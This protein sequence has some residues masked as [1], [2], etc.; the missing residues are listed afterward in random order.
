VTSA[1]PQAAARRLVFGLALIGNVVANAPPPELD[2]CRLGDYRAPTRK[3]IA[4]GIVLDTEA[5]EAL[6]KS[7][8]AAWIDVL[9]APRRPAN[10]PAAALW[11]PLPHR[12]IPSSLWLP[13]TG[14]GSLTPELEAS[15]RNDLAAATKVL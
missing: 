5:A 11:I 12:D 10:P 1:R 13:D 8:E 6:R 2:G 4:G 3:T 15:F 14:R 9:P 7:G